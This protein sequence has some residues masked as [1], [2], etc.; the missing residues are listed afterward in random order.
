MDIRNAVL[1]VAESSLPS[2]CE[3]RGVFA[4]DI[5]SLGW[6]GDWQTAQILV[7]TGVVYLYRI[8]AMSSEGPS[9]KFLQVKKMMYIK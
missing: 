8:E 2:T 4:W 7:V 3:L 1:A 5:D 9:Q 6:C